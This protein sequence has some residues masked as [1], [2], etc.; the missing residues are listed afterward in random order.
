MTDSIAPFERLAGMYTKIIPGKGHGVFCQNDIASGAVIESAPGLVITGTDLPLIDQSFLYNY[1]FS[2]KRLPDYALT[3]LGIVDKEKAGLLGLG[4]LSL[5]NHADKP[6]A[7]VL[8][9]AER[10][11]AILTLKALR[12]IP[13]EEEITI[14]YG[15][16]W[17]GKS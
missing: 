16:N 3:G 1:Y 10:G 4:L 2:A 11:R 12:S 13:A 14:S 6:N 7:E 17:Q 9:E 5:C 8:K 15:P